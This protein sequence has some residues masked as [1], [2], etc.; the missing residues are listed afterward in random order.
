MKVV[1]VGAAGQVGRNLVRLAL[2]RGDSVAATYK[3]RRPADDAVPLEPLDKTD[4]KACDLVLER[5]HPDVVIDTGAMH[6]VDYCETHADEANAVNR[7]GTRHLA[8]SAR[9]LGSRFVFISTDFVFD[10]SGP[11]PYLESATPRPQSIYAESKLAGEQATLATDSGNLVVR[12]SV[13]YSWLDTRQRAESSSGKGLNFGT[14]LA[15]EVACRRPVRIINDQIASPTLASDLAGAILALIEHECRGIVH[16]AGATAT[17]R[18]SFSVQL[19]SRLGLDSSLV[20]P[21]TTAELHQKALRPA[22]SSLASERLASE[23]G[24]RMMDL[25]AALDRFAADFNADPG[26]NALKS[27]APN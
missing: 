27:S 8:E 3:A 2:R 23:A 20:Q 1:V 16:T 18:F 21:V 5:L 12:P 25:P 7:E 10:G 6:N 15:E 22:V 9:R 19:V 26:T 13:I 11:T 4:A 17:D 24:Y 14:W